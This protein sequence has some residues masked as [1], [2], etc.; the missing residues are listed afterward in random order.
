ML[1]WTRATIVAAIALVCAHAAEASQGQLWSPTVGT[2]SGVQLTLTYNGGL[3]ALAS[4]NSG[5]AAPTNTQSGTPSLGMCWLNTS[6]TPNAVEV[7]DGS[8]WQIEGYIDATNHWWEPIV[9]G[10]EGTIAAASTTDLG[11]KP[12][13]FLTITGTA[14]ISSLGSSAP[15]GA[16]KI[17]AFGSSGSTL[18]NSSS[19]V[20][21]AGANLTTAAGD[22]AIAVQ[23]A[24]GIWNLLYF[25]ASGSPVTAVA[26]SGSVNKLRNAPLDI[27][28]RNPP[29]TVS[30]GTPQY[31][32]DGWSVLATGAAVTV[33]QDSGRLLTKYS[34]GITG[35][36]GA[37]DVQLAQPVESSF[38][39]AL[40]SQ[41]VTFQFEFYNATGSTAT[42]SIRVRHPTT[43]DT[44]ASAVTDVATTT[45]TACANNTWCREAYSWQASSNSA[46]GMEVIIDLGSILNSGGN[47]VQFAEFDLRATPGIASGL[48][49]APPPPE[50]LPVAN[51][52]PR[53]LRYYFT[54][55]SIPAVW[56]SN[57][58]TGNVRFSGFWPVPMFA[59][60]TITYNGGS[61]IVSSDNIGWTTNL[62][63]TSQVNIS[64]VSA[65]IAP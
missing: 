40:T 14:T 28:A 63:A 56:V 12:F 6:V 15:I 52:Y 5:S 22:S 11:T 47:Q 16:I 34:L 10:G 26:Q 3:A 51:E 50:L 24:A 7:Y 30:A 58:G 64:H 18:V 32:A 37:T 8:Q 65:E 44:Y 1:K 20:L 62:G 61:A 9:G 55:G 13:G 38:A 54:A 33:Q 29:M 4:C 57:A 27:W 36:S 43:A 48:V 42:P 39:A 45:L 21:P 59:A 19:L 23:S 25:T 60:P 46:L 17:I 35:A 41:Q 53:N 2:V 31:T 49:A